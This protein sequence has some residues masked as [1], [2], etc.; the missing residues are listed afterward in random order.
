ML[1]CRK[2][3]LKTKLTSQ[4]C[5]RREIRPKDVRLKLCQGLKSWESSRSLFL[6]ARWKYAKLISAMRKKDSLQGM[7]KHKRWIW[8]AIPIWWTICSNKICSLLCIWWPSKWLAQSSKALSLHRFPSHWVL[9]L[10]KCSSKGSTSQHLIPPMSAPCHGKCTPPSNMICF[11]LGLS[12]WF[13]DLMT[14]W[15]W[16]LLITK[17]SRRWKWWRLVQAWW[18]SQVNQRT[19][20][21]S[22]RQKKTSTRFWTT[23]LHSTM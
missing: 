5:L 14:F 23:S 8:W 22:L 13:M 6:R 18:L 11:S 16:C 4:R 10:S 7:S 15:D 9:S 19:T 20:R 2:R 1:T 12:S 17:R 3:P 21:R